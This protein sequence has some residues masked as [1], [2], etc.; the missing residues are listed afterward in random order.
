M[1]PAEEALIVCGP[2]G[3]TLSADYRIV[4]CDRLNR[5]DLDAL[6]SG[7]GNEFLGIHTVRLE[8]SARPDST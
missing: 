4:V 2:P 8:R 7:L 6:R 3:M 1:V 5:A